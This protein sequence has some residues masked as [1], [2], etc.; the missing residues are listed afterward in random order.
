MRSYYILSSILLSLTL[1]SSQVSAAV[2]DQSFPSERVRAGRTI[3]FHDDLINRS[4]YSII[5]DDARSAVNFSNI[6]GGT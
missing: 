6:Y 5:V 1:L 3:Y 4:S 2:C